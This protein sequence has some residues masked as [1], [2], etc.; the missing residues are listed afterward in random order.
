LNSFGQKEGKMDGKIEFYYQIP[1]HLS[2]NPDERLLDVFSNRLGLIE[3]K[4]A[5]AR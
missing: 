5:V 1:Q 2:V 3:A 4:D